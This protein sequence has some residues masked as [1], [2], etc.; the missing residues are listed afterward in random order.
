M[1]YKTKGIAWMVEVLHDDGW[2]AYLNF[3]TRKEARDWVMAASELMDDN[4]YRVVQYVQWG[5]AKKRFEKKRKEKDQEIWDSQFPGGVGNY[6][7]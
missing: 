3:D 1:N 6:E 7:L 2:L 4:K 5:V